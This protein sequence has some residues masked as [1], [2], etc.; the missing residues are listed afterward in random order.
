MT[1]ALNLAPLTAGALLADPRLAGELAPSNHP[2]ALLP[3]RLETRYAGGELLVRIYPDQVHVDAHDPRLSAAEQQAG[4]DFWRTQWRTGDNVARQQRAWKMLADR[5][6]AGRAGWVVRATRP[7][8]PGERPGTEVGD[9]VA[10]RPAP[11]FPT[12]EVSDDRRTPVARLLPDR[13]TVTAYAGGQVLAVATGAPIAADPPVGPDLAAPLVGDADDHEVA[14]VDQA[15][16]WL[17]DFAAAEEIGMAV[18]LPV[19]TPVDLLLATGVGR[20]DGAAGAD[21]LGALLSAQRY[22]S[23]L[24]FLPPDTPTNNSEAAGSG[25]SSTAAGAWS[26]SAAAPP[27]DSA[28]LA[29]AQ[30]LGL[31]DP[32]L[33]GSLPGAG[34]TGALLTRAMARALWPATWGYWLTQFVGVDAAT[35]DWGREFAG[36]FVRPE[37][38]LPTLRVGRQPYGLL[39]VTSLGR[40]A[41]DDRTTRLARVLGGLRDGAWRPAVDLAPRIGRSDVASDFV[42]VLRLEARSDDL[43]LRRSMGA[44]FADNLQRFLFRDLTDGGFW[45][46]ARDRSLPLARAAGLG[47]LPGA[48]TLH[49]PSDHP[50]TLPLVSAGDDVS[51]I[52]ALL[53]ADP[54]QL[55]GSTE[56]PESVLA[57]LLR[58]GLLREHAEAAA[59]LLSLDAA[60]AELYGFGDDAVGWAARRG[61]VLPDG[62]TVAAR[63]AGGSVPSLADFRTALGTLAQAP[64]PAL[65]RHLLDALDA[66]SHRLDAWVT[67]LAT[68]RLDQLRTSA[69]EGLLVGGYG[70][71]EGLAPTTDQVATELPTGESAPLLVAANDPGFVHAPSLH[72]AQVAALARNAHLAHGGGETDPFA[73]S[74]T[75]QRVRLARWIFDGVRAGRSLGA[76]LG[77]LVERDLHER[78]LDFAIVHAREAAP[79]PGQEALPPEARRLDGLRLHQLWA[80]G[81]DHA[82][83]H[84][85]AMDHTPTDDQ[86]RRAVAVLR[87]LNAAVDAAAD[88]LQAEQVHQF[89]RGDLSRAVSS[90]ADLDRGLAPPPELDFLA[91]PR[92]GAAV[93][94]RAIVLFD[95]DGATAAGWAGA[96]AAAAPIDPPRHSGLS[97]G[98]SARATAE[99]ALDAWLGSLLGPATGR[100]VTLAGD[101]PVPVPLPEL[102][103]AASEFVQLAGGGSA[104][105]ELA[106]RAALAADR[107]VESAELMPDADLLALLEL[108]GSLAA[109]V[110]HAT[111]LD[112]AGLQPPHADPLPGVDV[113]ELANRTTAARA[114]VAAVAQE[115][116]AAVARPEDD[117]ALHAAVVAAWPLAVGEGGVPTVKSGWPA[118]AA[119]VLADLTARLAEPV[120]P[121]DDAR[122]LVRELATLLGPGFVAVPR[123][124][125]A[126]SAAVIASRDDA[127]LVGGDPLAAEVW[128]TRMERVREPLGRLG[129]ALREADALGGAPFEVSVA[130]VPYTAGDTWNALPARRYV[131]AAASLLVVG[132]AVVRPGAALTGL[133]IDEWAEV[134]PAASETTGVAF[135]YDPPESMAPQAILLAVPPVLDE[136]WT[137]AGLNQVLVETLELAHLRAVP[138]AALGPARQYLPA[139]VLAYNAEGDAP[140]TDPNT[141]TPAGG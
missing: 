49:E 18:R 134:V 121:R 123:F 22:S 108:G 46:A 128:L 84:L 50:V 74:L 141:L 12:L 6:G 130:Q 68:A 107:P 47:L 1:A 33:F 35:N 113:A 26:P 72:Q 55:A 75:S 103:L 70:W 17:V 140:S 15:M 21:R 91:T 27:P 39:P 41:G 82:V 40:F 45:T 99:P 77:Y 71:V 48:L 90:V 60:D 32:E 117:E 120:A 61:S 2:L 93:T 138:P 126:T 115:L 129:I 118:A 51:F 8:N 30:A 76:V 69:A 135:R 57:V 116:S 38:P 94:H 42:D 67:A 36:L 106:A 114:A 137:V 88:A 105:R 86:R 9:D 37:G 136:V 52:G 16:N 124:V 4:Q 66:T 85:V 83:D 95:P 97:A 109:L 54:D 62:G 13:W 79:L 56:T 102:R 92:T 5:Y 20:Q 34:D 11:A 131:D 19:T 73:V 87:G 53:A 3:V 65:E 139:A 58:H 23:G 89:A 125:A 31:A 132:G 7:S 127:G 81:E 78:D 104:L 44:R 119:R 14:A 101:P 122:A 10:P 24:G 63:L 64:V 43:R 111:P 98:I 96:A 100:T 80:G 59:R 133:Q 25:W 29:A 28:G 110:S 112:G